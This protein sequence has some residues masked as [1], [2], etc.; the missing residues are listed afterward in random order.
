MHA[1]DMQCVWRWQPCTCG[2]NPSRMHSSF[3][4]S[5]RSSN[6]WGSDFSGTGGIVHKADSTWVHVRCCAG[7]AATKQQAAIGAD[8]EDPSET[9][10]AH[11][12]LFVVRVMPTIV[13]CTLGAIA[14]RLMLCAR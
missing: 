9:S 13:A 11:G 10:G 4:M 12:D 2:L 7:D 5:A 3:L 6:E 1:L 14:A 8:V